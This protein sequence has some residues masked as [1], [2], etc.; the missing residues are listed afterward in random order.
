MIGP[1]LLSWL[2]GRG[3]VRVHVLSAEQ[4]TAQ[5]L[6]LRRR[7]RLQSSI[8]LQPRYFHIGLTNMT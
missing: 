7:E 5:S 1:L 4:S 2:S 8:R 3:F 6:L